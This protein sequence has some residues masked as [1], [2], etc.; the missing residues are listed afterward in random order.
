MAVCASVFVHSRRSWGVESLETFSSS[1][2]NH[3][4]GRRGREGRRAAGGITIPQ[5]HEEENPTNALLF[6][7][8]P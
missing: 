3:P 7:H 1:T 2:L 4:Q 8:T 5:P 6:S